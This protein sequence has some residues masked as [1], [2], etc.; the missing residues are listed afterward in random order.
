[1]REG[2]ESRLAVSRFGIDDRLRLVAVRISRDGIAAVGHGEGVDQLLRGAERSV[3]ARP[4]HA[5]RGGDTPVVG[6]DDAG[7][8]HLCHAVDRPDRRVQIV[9]TA[10]GI[11]AVGPD[12]T[13]DVHVDHVF[14]GL[15]GSLP[16]LLVV[17][18]GEERVAVLVDHA[19][20]EVVAVEEFAGRI[21]IDA[22]ADG[23]GRPFGGAA[24][25]SRRPLLREAFGGFVEFRGHV[26][27]ALL[28]RVAFAFVQVLLLV[29]RGFVAQ[30]EHGAEGGH[31]QR[32]VVGAQ[33]AGFVV[34]VSLVGV[35]YFG[36]F[37]DVLHEIAGFA[38]TL[39]D[40][41]VG[42]T[43]LKIDGGIPRGY[44]RGAGQ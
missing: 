35:A 37:V 27:D 28:P 4:G 13:V 9:Q 16:F 11:G 17:D 22:G 26:V 44:E 23:K 2:R 29:I 19:L 3:G 34:H 43:A 41:V 5:G 7:E 12:E 15:C 40:V 14:G 42:V 36:A 33:E 21:E 10:V 18:R 25:F 24:V 32:I 38:D 30:N 20:V 31:Q 1:M 39:V 8:D 6:A